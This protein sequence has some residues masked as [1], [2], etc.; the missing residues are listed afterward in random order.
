MAKNGAVTEGS[1]SSILVFIISFTFFTWL[2]QAL[3]TI[4]PRGV[5]RNNETLVSAGGVF[6]LGFFGDPFSGYRF[7]G[8]W[9]KIDT[10]KKAVWVAN[11][12]NPLVDTT[13]FL[14]ISDD[15]NLVLMDRRQIPVIVNSGGLATAGSTS[16]TLLDSGNLVLHGG[17]NLT[18]QSFDYPSDTYLPGMKLGWFGLTT[19]QPRI[20]VLSSWV[21]PLS[22]LRGAFTLGVSYNAPNMSVY[23]GDSAHVDIGFWDG[24]QVKFIFKNSFTSLNFSYVSNEH[25]SYFTFNTIGNYTMSWL[26]LDSTGQVDEYTLYNQNISSVSHSLCEDPAI[27]FNAT[28]LCLNSTSSACKEGDAFSVVDGFLPSSAIVNGLIGLGFRDCELVCQGNC[29]CTAF[30]CPENGQTGCQLYY[31]NKHDL[32]NIIA[33][34]GGLVYVRGNVSIPTRNGNGSKRNMLWW[35]LAGS[36]VLIVLILVSIRCFVQRRKRIPAAQVRSQDD[37]ACGN[38]EV[39]MLQ[40]GN[41]AT[42][43]NEAAA[44]KLELSGDKNQ[45][46]PMFS[47]S[48]IETATNY[49]AIANMIGE[50]GFGPVYK[51]NLP[52]GEEIAVKRLS[53]KSGQGLMEFKNEITLISKLQH[54]NLVRL[55]GCCIQGEENILVYEYMPNRSLDSFLF[56]STKR[57]LL[58]WKKRVKIIEG[59]AQGIL[60]LHKYSRLKIIHRDLKTSNILL[61]NDMTPKI[62]DFGMARIFGENENRAKTNKVVGTFGYMSPEY[63]MDGLFSEKS[64]VF[65]FGIIVLE[66]LSGKK[67]IAF[68]ELDQSQNLLG[69]AWNLWKEGRSMELMDSKL[70]NSCSSSEVLRYV[71]LCLLCV[72]GRAADRPTMSDVILMLSNETVALPRP[73]EPA[74]LSYI[75]TTDGDSSKSKQL[76]Q[77]SQTTLSIISVVS[78]R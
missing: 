23:R 28:A 19:D 27:V 18:W 2:S 65:S 12:E 46:L 7:L 26:V 34:G 3:E 45:E 77:S 62:S 70:S 4:S 56:D 61:D 60:Y 78:G 66:I 30:A 55:L 22:P 72:Q 43:M 1:S 52:Q 40:M 29:S 41:N 53:K 71:Q 16:A 76:G 57:A 33:K 48:T 6:E 37:E 20:Q 8:I 50:G 10:N 24:N 5:L 73:K 54:R 35:I 59:I 42:S 68:F 47:F 13:C 36:A 63:A 11:R 75:S 58:D 44:A 74:M 14:Q 51:G 64:D 38:V 17:G 69:H 9:L 49:F 39:T 21:G 25:E 67:N 31:G 32:S 15:G